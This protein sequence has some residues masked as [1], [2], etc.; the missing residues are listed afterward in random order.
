MRPL[1]HIAAGLVMVVVDL[2]TEYVDLLPDTVGWALVALGAWHLAM[3]GP[4]LAAVAT[5]LLAVPEVS[6]PYRYVRV[7]PET[8]ETIEPQPGVQLDVPRQL[9]FDDLSGWRVAM[10]GVATLAA[11]VTL[12][13]LLG[14]LSTRAGAWQRAVTARRLHLLR[15]LVLVAWLVPYLVVIAASVRRDGSFDPV[16]NDR[17][18][19]VAL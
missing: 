1:T 18:E 17:L 14:A 8:G 19:L 3:T 16:W 10:V 4:A 6:L 2:R 15:W 12:W 9:V 7:H 5:A 13:W 11:A